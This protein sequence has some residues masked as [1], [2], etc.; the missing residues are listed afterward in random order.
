MEENKIEE[1]QQE[2][3]NV[4]GQAM[5]IAQVA[6]NLY[7]EALEAGDYEKAKQFYDQWKQACD[8]IK[9]FDENTGAVYKTDAEIAAKLEMNRLDNETKLKI[10]EDD[11]ALRRELHEQEM[12]MQRAQFIADMVTRTVNTGVTIGQNYLWYNMD[13]ARMAWETA[14]YIP[15][16]SKTARSMI[17]H[18]NKVINTVK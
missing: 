6:G 5:Q 10:A 17:N 2:T 15:D 12:I 13:T 16:N 14:G 8:R 7:L 18:G 3:I 11:A 1:T 9:E 4:Y